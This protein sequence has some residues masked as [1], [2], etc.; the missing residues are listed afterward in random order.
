MDAGEVRIA[1]R[2][3]G[4]DRIEP[5]NPVQAFVVRGHAGLEIDMPRAHAGRAQRVP[6]PVPGEKDILRRH[7][8]PQ[9]NA[10]A[11]P[12]RPTC[13]LAVE[14]L[15]ATPA[16]NGWGRGLPNSFSR[17]IAAPCAAISP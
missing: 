14:G 5:E 9:L 4:F 3:L 17:S 2:A 6:E 1:G 7:R 13:R 8:L 11:M 12:Q 10:Q 16:R 15:S